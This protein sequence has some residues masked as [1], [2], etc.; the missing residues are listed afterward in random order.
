M[1]HDA[2]TGLEVDSSSRGDSGFSPTHWTVVF[3]GAQNDP[4]ALET[5]CRAYWF[6]I[7]T[8]VRCRGFD[9]HTA[10]DLTQGFFAYLL[11]KEA[12]KKV[13]SAKGR[14]RSF[15]LAS[16]TNFLS[17]EWDR[18]QT[19]KRGGRRQFISLDDS[20]EDACQREAVESSTPEKHFEQRWARA[21]LEHALARLKR[22]YLA[23]GKAP[24]FALLEPS[25]TLDSSGES[26]A[27][28]AAKVGMTEGAVN[29]ALHRLRRRY[30]ELLRQEIARTVS[31][32]AEVDDEIRHLFSAVS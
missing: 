5:L 18:Q 32:P 29:V 28:L 2:A 6:P 12:L 7:Y 22:E 3:A 17:N 14:F 23:T 24:L 27:A 19:V 25:L 10:E 1:D 21:L 11:A 20:A 15:I 9:Q 16:L 8:F 13:D 26:I 30:G 31:S 4:A